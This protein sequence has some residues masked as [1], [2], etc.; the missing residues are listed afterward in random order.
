MA[1]KR[2]EKLGIKQIIQIEWMDRVVQMLLAGMSET[3]IRR[4]LD[5]YLT[6]Q[7]TKGGT[8]KRS[9]NTKKKAIGILGSW[10]P[11]DKELVPFCESALK[12]A[13]S[14]QPSEW[15]PLHWAVISASYPFWFNVAKQVGRI[16]NLQDKVTQRQIF[17]RLKEQYGDRETVARIA[18][19]TVRSFVAWN[20]LR[21]SKKK[22]CYEI[23]GS[24][25]VS[26]SNV[27]IVLF[28]SAL[29]ALPEGKCALGGLTNNP[30]FF[31]FQIPILN[32]GYIAQN[33]DRIDVVHYGFDDELLKLN[34]NS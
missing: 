34:T 31:P 33:C 10:F 13:S 17:D 15:L 18:R 29:H 24:H 16:L 23:S 7:G 11:K 2:H 5:E 19:Y 4:D 6:D 9:E 3:D 25:I 28:E 1:I 22:G 20:V 12:L 26:D 14:T 30:G 8:G 27:A 32:A 21:D